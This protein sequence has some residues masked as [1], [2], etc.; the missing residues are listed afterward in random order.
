MKK[1]TLLL[2]I[3]LTFLGCS[4]MKIED[5]KDQKPNFNLN[6]Y[7]KGKTNAWGIFED[8]FG[9]LKRQFKVNIN[10]YYKDGF[11]IL[12]EDFDYL[13][14]EKDKRLWKIKKLPNGFYQG[15][16]G[17]VIGT[18]KGQEIGNAFTWSYDINLKIGSRNLKVKFN[19][20]LFRMDEKVVINKAS[21]S[22]FGINIGTVTL[23]FMKEF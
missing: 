19:D 4:Q 22:K 18:A 5:F 11:L 7:F 15:T 13:D 17:D 2:L 9:N 6:E 16:A 3:I 20:W 12:E 23:F 10:G 8:R 21:V 14:G 1:I